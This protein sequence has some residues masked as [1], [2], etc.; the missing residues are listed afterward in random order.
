MIL[1]GIAANTG[2]SEKE[3]E[4]MTVDRA[5]WWWNALAAYQQ[6]CREAT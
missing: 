5:K 6:K 2:F 4:G 3:I 1:G